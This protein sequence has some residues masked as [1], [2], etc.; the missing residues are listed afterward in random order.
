MFNAL[1]LTVARLGTH[2]TT[3]KSALSSS[4]QKL[5]S[6]KSFEQPKDGVAEF[7]RMQQIRLDRKGFSEVTRNLT[8]ATAVLNVAESAATEIVDSFTRLK[9]V[10]ELYHLDSTTSTEKKMYELEFSNIL[11]NIDM[12]KENTTFEG[13]R[14]VQDSE[15][16]TS[17]M[18]DPND[19]SKTLT[20]EYGS[21]HMVDTSM[22]HISPA[23]GEEEA[24]AA[25]DEQMGNALSYLARTSGFLRSVGS[26]IDLVNSKVENGQAYESTI[27]A[28][29]DVEELS[30]MVTHDIRQQ[31]ALSMIL[32]ANT[33]RQ[34]ILRLVG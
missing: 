6:G 21:E 14:L 25:L 32:H 22:L 28:I 19:L 23:G 18:L 15:V 12:I 29:N 16:I 27:G 26:Q 31:A 4:L 2:Y 7:M 34:G 8:R 17:V 1:N 9:E 3:S 11:V 20:I 24:M 10:T 30:R 33:A 13:R 5:S